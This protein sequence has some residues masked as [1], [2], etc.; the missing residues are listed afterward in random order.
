MTRRIFT[1][2]N[3]RLRDRAIECI[4]E[5]PPNSRVEVK[6]PKRSND[7]NAAMWCKLGDIAEQIPWE[8]QGEL[9][10][11]DTEQWKLMF[12]DALRRERR[13]Q[14][15]VVLNIDRTGFVDIG[16]KHSSDLSGEEM[17]MLLALISAFGDER[18]VVWSEPKPKDQRPVPPVEAYE[19]ALR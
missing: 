13:D 17:G 6:G 12:L 9:R 16:D 11:L 14:L 19:E 5:V 7:A 10:K 15:N 2:A 18:G 8:V 3:Q 4:R 1:L